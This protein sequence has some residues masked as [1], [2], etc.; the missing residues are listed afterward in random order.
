MV[1]MQVIFC[2][3]YFDIY[4]VPLC[5][6]EVCALDFS[7][8]GFGLCPSYSTSLIYWKVVI[9]FNQTKPTCTG[10]GNLSRVAKVWYAFTTNCIDRTARYSLRVI[11]CFRHC[12]R[13]RLINK[14]I[15][16]Y[17]LYKCLRDVLLPGQFKCILLVRIYLKT[18]VLLG[19]SSPLCARFV[20]S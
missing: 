18:I 12:L 14:A 20:A 2:F 16:L 7:M 19:R 13:K 9:I 4:E 3:E 8:W 5:V 17:I 15:L 10:N 6:Y 1:L 11:G